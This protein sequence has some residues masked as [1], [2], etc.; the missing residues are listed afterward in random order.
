MSV[1]ALFDDDHI[2][3]Q[4]NNVEKADQYR[5]EIARVLQTIDENWKPTRRLSKEGAFILFHRFLLLTGDEFLPEIDAIGAAAVM[6]SNKIHGSHTKTKDAMRFAGASS[7]LESVVLGLE[8]IF[9]QMVMRLPPIENSH[10]R[11][12]YRAC[13]T[14]C[15]VALE[16]HVKVQRQ[17]EA[18]YTLMLYLPVVAV[19]DPRSVCECLVRLALETQP[20]V[21]TPTER[22]HIQNVLPRSR[23]ELGLYPKLLKILMEN[24]AGFHFGLGEYMQRCVARNMEM[25]VSTNQTTTSIL[26]LAH[27]TSTNQ[28][29]HQNQPR[30]HRDEELTTADN[31]NE[32]RGGQAPPKRRKVP[33]HRRT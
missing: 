25:F 11:L 2:Q 19:Y 29:H 28:H 9:L 14:A 27:S 16:Q 17:F 13:V 1:I 22:A 7:K 8:F 31:D 5:S 20:T 32:D 33:F 26:D 6:T 24:A 21:L 12:H 3:V 4:I 10:P 30:R 15:K 18:L 23:D